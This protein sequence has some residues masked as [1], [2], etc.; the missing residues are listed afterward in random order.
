V[1]S[2][3]RDFCN[4]PPRRLNIWQNQDRGWTLK[5][6]SRALGVRDQR[7]TLGIL[8]RQGLSIETRPRHTLSEKDVET[9]TAAV[10]KWRAER[11]YG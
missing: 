5:T 6:L 1:A 11:L 8:K 2:H 10:L 9:I 4:N 3:H 7:S